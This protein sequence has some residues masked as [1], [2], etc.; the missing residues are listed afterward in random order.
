MKYPSYEKYFTDALAFINSRLSLYPYKR[1]VDEDGSTMS[2]P[3]TYFIKVF[4]ADPKQGKVAL[5]EFAVSRGFWHSGIS[6][7]EDYK[8]MKQHAD[9]KLNIL[10]K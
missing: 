4:Y 2:D 9:P 7:R 3:L 1:S 8:W 10:R 5:F 6:N